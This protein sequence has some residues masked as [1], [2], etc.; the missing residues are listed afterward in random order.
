MPYKNLMATTRACLSHWRRWHSYEIPYYEQPYYKSWGHTSRV[1]F[2]YGSWKHYPPLKDVRLSIFA[3]AVFYAGLFFI[4]GPDKS[5][6]H[7]DAR[8]Q[9]IT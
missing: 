6:N 1:D 4:L 3:L 5:K 8:W 7:P 9:C 2:I